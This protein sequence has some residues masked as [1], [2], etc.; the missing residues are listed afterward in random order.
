[1]PNLQ[2]YVRGHALQPP[3]PPTP[4]RSKLPWNTL[5]I[6]GISK[7]DLCREF[8]GNILPMGV[9][10]TTIIFREKEKNLLKSHRSAALSLVR[11]SLAVFLEAVNHNWNG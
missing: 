3:P 8:E 11:E 10:I 6:T 2:F 9:S 5:L 7:R 4:F 1:M